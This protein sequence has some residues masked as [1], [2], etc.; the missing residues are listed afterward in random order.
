MRLLVGW[1][2]REKSH[3]RSAGHSKDTPMISIS[4]SKDTLMIS[5]SD[6]K[7]TL[8]ISIGAL[9]LIRADSWISNV[10]LGFGSFP[11]QVMS[12]MNDKV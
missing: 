4:D 12:N 9:G 5:I 2:R 11:H 1:A 10:G 6:S 8:M 3:L 7:D